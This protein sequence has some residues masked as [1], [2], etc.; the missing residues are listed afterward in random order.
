VVLA[1]QN[2]TIP[3]HLNLEEPNPYIPWNELPVTVP[4]Q[5]TEWKTAEGKRRIAGISSFGFSGTNSHM[6]IAE[7][8]ATKIQEAVFERTSHL[9]TLSAK[10][11]VALKEVARRYD[12][13]LQLHSTAQLAD[14]KYSVNTGRSHFPHRL[15]LAASSLAQAQEKLSAW[16]RGES[17]GV[18]A[19]SAERGKPDV[20]FLF[21]GQ[22]AQYAGMAR[23]LYET[24]PTF[25][26]MMDEC[27]AILHPHLEKPLLSVI[28]P[29]NKEDESLIHQTPIPS[30]P[31][32]MEYSLAKL[33][34][35]WEWNRGRD[36]TQCRR[37]CG[38]R[39]KVFSLTPPAHRSTR[40]SDAGSA[41]GGPMAPCLQTN[42]AS[43]C[44]CWRIKGSSTPR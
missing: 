8:P 44:H 39:R 20:V 15:A 25:R 42:R 2:K 10:R 24:Q 5:L 9:F 6:V 18:F 35:S 17:T 27:E 14:V 26:R 1:L 29:Q 37:I 34:Q 4:T 22:G 43:G 7:A 28:Y 12:G 32:A 30:L 19:G 11:E 21:T 31:F 38:C 23:Q 3:P 13:F 33:W 16:N 36:G 40:A 41:C